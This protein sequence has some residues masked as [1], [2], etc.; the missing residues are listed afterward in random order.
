MQLKP[1]VANKP[2]ECPLRG[3]R[4]AVLL[5]AG[6]VSDARP[7][8]EL[9]ALVNEGM[10]VDLICLQENAGEPLE[11]ICG[12]LRVT[13]IPIR[14]DRF[15]K[16]GY[17]R[18][19]GHFFLRSFAALTARSV[20]RR[21]DVIHIHNMPDALAFAAL[22]PRLLGAKI[23]LDLHDPMPE[24]YQTIYGTKPDSGMM[25]LLKR[26]EK[27]SIRFAHLVLTP[28]E[29]FR[30][31]FCAR[32]CPPSKIQ[33]IMNSPDEELFKPVRPPVESVDGALPRPEFRLMYHGLIAERHGL[34]TAVEAVGRLSSDIPGIVLDMFGERNVFLDQIMKTAKEMGLGE[35]I[36]YQGMRPLDDIP[37]AI[38][39]ADLGLV[40]NQRTPF[41][42]INFPTRIFE[43]LSVN[44]PVIVPDTKGIRDYFDENQILYFK[45]GSAD[46]LAR[47]IRWVYE[48]PAETASV[49]KRGREVYEQH[50]WPQE[51]SRFLALAEG[52][53]TNRATAVK[54]FVMPEKV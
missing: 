48:H 34:T 42:E 40:P 43:Y 44:K 15:R 54:C 41:T 45:P 26:M 21:Y 19:Y 24:L 29:A 51:K 35:R 6:I 10:S 13:R 23:I 36:R 47:V 1:E 30:R 52:L 27:W 17:F 12:S 3:K 5:Y 46:D 32:G 14:H 25:G 50:R 53:L 49:L 38:A 22:V 2:V 20:S 4:A 33:I 16:A 31:I 28:N 9:E 7:R 39:Q 37:A 11:E 8:R 18:N